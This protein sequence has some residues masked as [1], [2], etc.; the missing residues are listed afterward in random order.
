MADAAYSAWLHSFRVWTSHCVYLGLYL[1]YAYPYLRLYVRGTLHCLLAYC[2]VNPKNWSLWWKLGVQ[3][4]KGLRYDLHCIK[5]CIGTWS[6]HL[7]P[8]DPVG[9]PLVSCILPRLLSFL[10]RH[11]SRVL[12]HFH[13]ATWLDHQHSGGGNENGI[14][15]SPPFFFPRVVKN[16]L[17]TRLCPSVHASWELVHLMINVHC[18]TSCIAGRMHGWCRLMNY[19]LCKFD[20]GIGPA[21][22]IGNNMHAHSDT[23]PGPNLP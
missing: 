7:W 15:R 4:W 23:E 16:G 10:G 17:G 6:F 20:M 12:R 3:R 19:L 2:L 1:D 22:S 9:P 11:Y 13:K 5:A 8:F 21:G 18:F 14:G